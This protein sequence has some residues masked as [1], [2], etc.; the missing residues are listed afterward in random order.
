MRMPFPDHADKVYEAFLDLNQDDRDRVL[1]QLTENVSEKYVVMAR[2]AVSV[3]RK[4]AESANHSARFGWKMAQKA[5]RYKRGP[6]AKMARTK[7]CL[8][9]VRQVL[10][11]GT[12]PEPRAVLDAMLR[13]EGGGEFARRKNGD[14]VN[15][16]T[17]AR[18][19]ARLG[20]IADCP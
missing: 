11:A 13:I 7:R 10:G 4:V 20:Q 9:L 5:R 17:V 2:S 12:A 19:L 6:E 8:D 18:W 1:M 3:L 15:L 16:K 14:V